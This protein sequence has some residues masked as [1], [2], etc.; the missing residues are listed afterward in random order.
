MPKPAFEGRNEIGSMKPLRVLVVE[1][2]EADTTLAIFE[3]ERAGLTCAHQRVETR[4]AT[5]AAL[6]Q[7]GWDVIIADYRMPGFSGLEALAMMQERQIDVPFIIV[8]GTIGEETAVEAMRAG[9]HDYVLKENLMRL[10]AAVVRELREAQVRRER[11]AALDANHEMAHRSAFLAEASRRLASS[12]DDED[13]LAQAARVLVPDIADWCLIALD[14]QADDEWPGRLRTVL[15]HRDPAAEARGRALLAGYPL[16]VEAGATPRGLS[17]ASVRPTTPD[18]VLTTSA[19]A[20]ESQAVLRLLGHHAGVCVPLAAR[21]RSM[22]TLTLVW[23]APRP[24]P[25]DDQQGFLQDVATRVAV[26]LENATLYRKAREAVRV[27]EEFLS[28]ASHELN[29]PLATL[30]L[31][32]DELLR[33]TPAGQGTGPPNGSLRR[34]RRQ[35]ERLTRLVGNLLDLSQMGARRLQLKLAPVDLASVTREV[36]EQLGPELARAACSLELQAAAPVEG[37]WDAA[38]LAQVVTNL[39]SNACKFGAGKPLKVSV[40]A[41]RDRARLSVRDQGVGIAAEDQRRIFEPFGRAA[42]ARHHYGGLGL[43]LYITRQLVEAH[44]GTIAVDSAPGAGATFV[45]DLPLH[46]PEA[47]K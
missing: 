8:S 7:G 31:E 37:Q 6:D 18:D 33:R 17:G 11:R 39:L 32:V 41:D 35:L 19:P 46:P 4:Q 38:R 28:V 24:H 1:D 12:L 42:V 20:G 3:L 23:S 27:R 25:A 14:G 45:V 34:A 30:T 36:V 5:A 40:C 10:G 9:A 22:G 2:S 43:G 15:R 13:T 29:T 26:A 47:T 16:S 21:D 44:R